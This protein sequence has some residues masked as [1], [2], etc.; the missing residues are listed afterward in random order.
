MDTENAS[1]RGHCRKVRLRLL[2]L[3]HIRIENR[4]D[5]YRGHESKHNAQESGQ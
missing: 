3:A 1:S 5:K 4:E 2:L